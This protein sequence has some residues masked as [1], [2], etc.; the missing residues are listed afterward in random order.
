MTRATARNTIR[1]MPGQAGFTLL[2]LLVVLSVLAAV[3]GIGVLALGGVT[4][5]TRAE[6]VRAEMNQIA[7]AIRRF[8]ADTG[9]WPKEGVFDDDNADDYEHPANFAQLKVQPNRDEGTPPAD[10]PILPH[11]LASDN[12][13]NGPYLRE[14]DAVTVT[15]GA[16]L[17]PDGT[18]DPTVGTAQAVNGVGDPFERAAE[19]PYFV[20]QDAGGTEIARLGRPYLY[21]IDETANDNIT[22]C[23]RPCLL[24][25]GENGQY[26]RGNADDIVINIA[27]N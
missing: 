2:E 6:L 20:W 25:M 27:G 16:N 19:P 26:D 5:D 4:Q 13:W 8:R 12:G 18:G 3:A 10:E 15:V 22:G 14:L 1:P 23:I 21:F 7:N 9:Y 17:Q 24:S 11:D